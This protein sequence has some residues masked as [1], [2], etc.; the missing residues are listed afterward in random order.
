MTLMSRVLAAIFGL[1]V[2]IVVFAIVLI[3][4]SVIVNFILGNRSFPNWFVIILYVF[5]F[6]LPTLLGIF[7]AIVMGER[8]LYMRGRSLEW[9][10]SSRRRRLEF[11]ESVRRDEARMEEFR[12]RFNFPRNSNENRPDR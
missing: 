1:I 3:L 4:L 9:E 8:Y 11:E 6:L 5:V 7:F 2:G 12:N 10:E